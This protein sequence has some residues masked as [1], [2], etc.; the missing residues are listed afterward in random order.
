MN[1]LRTNDLENGNGHFARGLS[2]FTLIELLAVMA[3]ILL[4]STILLQVGKFARLKAQMTRANSD[5]E[6]YM[7]GYTSY[8]S[9]NGRYPD[10]SAVSAGADFFESCVSLDPWNRSYLYRLRI[11]LDGSNLITSE[12]EYNVG[13]LGPDGAPGRKGVDDDMADPSHPYR[14]NGVDRTV[15][16]EFGYGD[17]IVKGDSSTYKRFYP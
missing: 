1:P 7:T 11:Y 4:L 5:I 13:S 9:A 12:L 10:N 3:I 6:R 16:T 15:W 2:S 8:R 14:S 17:D